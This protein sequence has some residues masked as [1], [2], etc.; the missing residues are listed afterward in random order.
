MSLIDAAAW[1]ILL[2]KIRAPPKSP[3]KGHAIRG[4]APALSLWSR[5]GMSL[6]VWFGSGL[7]VY[8]V[9]LVPG[10]SCSS[11][12]GCS[13][14]SMELGAVFFFFFSYLSSEEF[15]LGPLSR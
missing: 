11:S 1:E 10:S 15:S 7:L 4:V 12:Q 9:F 2:I 6:F 14:N 8:L 3:Q 13:A 5:V